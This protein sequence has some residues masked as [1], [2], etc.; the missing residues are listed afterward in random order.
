MSP[1]L[2]PKA[3]KRRILG[4]SWTQPLSHL[5]GEQMERGRHERP[6]ENSSAAPCEDFLVQE[7][8]Q[9]FR[10]WPLL[11]TRWGLI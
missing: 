9:E 3:G 10:L 11:V 6:G 4:P 8:P 1:L 7:F 2:I 5:Q